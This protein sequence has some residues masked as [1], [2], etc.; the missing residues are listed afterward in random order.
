M[1][2]YNRHFH[3]EILQ[4]REWI[5]IGYQAMIV[6]SLSTIILKVFVDTGPRI[7]FSL[8]VQAAPLSY[9][10]VGNII[11]SL[12]ALVLRMHLNIIWS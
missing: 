10:K 5:H 6:L 3:D 1:V 11:V 7:Y 12:F 8:E 9:T 2:Y 4:W